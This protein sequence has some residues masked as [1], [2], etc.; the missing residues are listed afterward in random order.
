[1]SADSAERRVKAG[2]NIGNF[3]VVVTLKQG[4]NHWTMQESMTDKKHKKV[5][6]LN[7]ALNSFPV[8][9]PLWTTRKTVQH[10]YTGDGWR[11]VHMTHE[12]LLVDERPSR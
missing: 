5:L 2:G 8:S 1:M 11:A 4:S 9:L 6:Y 12:K 3:N 7:I 10:I